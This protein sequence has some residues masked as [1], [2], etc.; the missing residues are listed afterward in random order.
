MK[1]FS[2]GRL[3]TAAKAY[4]LVLMGTSLANGMIIKPYEFEINPHELFSPR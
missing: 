1:V 4:S 3:K 2:S